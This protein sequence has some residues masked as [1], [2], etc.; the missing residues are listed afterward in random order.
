MTY[1]INAQVSVIE[2]L[3]IVNLVKGSALNLVNADSVISIHLASW[4]GGPVDLSVDF[5]QWAS[6]WTVM[7][8]M[9]YFIALLNSISLAILGHKI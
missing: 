5:D 3:P 9:I 4:P 7:G 2:N 8:A 6:I 1:D